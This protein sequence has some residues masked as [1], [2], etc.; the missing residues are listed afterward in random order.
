M[1]EH[2]ARRRR[3][4]ASREEAEEAGTSGLS[5]RAESVEIVVLPKDAAAPGPTENHY[6]TS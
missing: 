5:L 3:G 6:Q 4:F 1:D 2:R